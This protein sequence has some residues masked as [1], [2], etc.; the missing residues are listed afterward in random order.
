MAVEVTTA[1]RRRAW[2]AT[3]THFPS[4]A[5]RG[6]PVDFLVCVSK[7]NLYCCSSRCKVNP[8]GETHYEALAEVNRLNYKAEQE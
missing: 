2:Q 6:L 8:D 5:H 3:L 4:E 1:A 7:T